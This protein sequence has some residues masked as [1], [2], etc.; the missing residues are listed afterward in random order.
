MSEVF[1]PGDGWLANYKKEQESRRAEK[2][3]GLQGQL[4]AII[5]GMKELKAQMCEVRFDGCGDSG[6]VEEII[7]TGAKGV[8]LKADETLSDLAERFCYDY[9]DSKG[10][11]WYNN[12]GGYGNLYISSSGSAELNVSQRI[13]STEDYSFTLKAAKKRSVK[14]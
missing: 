14:K 13:V 2:E 11:D 7:F 5:S 9:L 6:M 1:S 3:S 12:E 10:I 8:K 4:K